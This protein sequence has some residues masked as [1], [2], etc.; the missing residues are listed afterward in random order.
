MLDIERPLYRYVSFIL[1]AFA[2]IGIGFAGPAT[3][4]RGFIVLQMTPGRLISDFTVSGGIGGVML[5]AAAVGAIALGLI[6]LTAVRLSGPTIAAVFTMM[7]FSFF[8]TSPFNALPIILGVFLASRLARTPFSHYI[9]IAFFGTALG[10]LLDFLFLEMGL[11]GPL[12]LVAGAA[13]SLIAGV[14][15]PALAMAMLRLHQG[16]NLYNIGFTAGFIGLFSASLL[17]AAGGDLS[18]SVVWNEEVSLILISVIP[19]LSLVSFIAALATEGVRSIKGVASILKLS[20]R[21]PS[22]FMEQVSPGAALVNMG[23][24]GLLG[25]A[26]VFL[27]GGDFNGPTIGALMT[28]MG[29]AAFG[30]HPR[31]CVPVMAGVLA[32][33]V[34]FGK[35]PAAPGPLLAIIFGTTL[36]PLAGEFG[37]AIGFVAGF[38][39][40]TIVERSAAWHGGLNLYNNGFAGGL[41]AALIVAV[42]EWHK[43]RKS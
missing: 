32:A 16:F 11:P 9:L 42:L 41:T 34:A 3:A 30:K 25:S 21:L 39:H 4:L 6:R 35:D 14:L 28:L 5:N 8:G 17:T 29:F 10:P 19:A 40:L 7:G 38:L 27:I 2:A 1:F 15:F 12:A 23:V 36:A 20:G 22:D 26:Y 18:L 37:A 33:T 43:S 31:N 24:L 13:G